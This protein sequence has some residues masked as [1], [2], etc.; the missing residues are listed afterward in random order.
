MVILSSATAYAN[1]CGYPKPAYINGIVTSRESAKGVVDVLNDELRKTHPDQTVKLAYNQTEGFTLDLV[2]S[3]YQKADSY[4]M[5]TADASLLI[6]GVIFGRDSGLRDA[7]PGFLNDI[8]AFFASHTSD[9]VAQFSKVKPVYNQTLKDITGIMRDALAAGPGLYIITHSQGSLFANDALYLLDQNEL[10]AASGKR[11]STGTYFIAP[12][13]SSQLANYGRGYTKFN[14]DLL[15]GLGIG[16]AG[17]APLFASSAEEATYASKGGDAQYHGMLDA[18]FNAS[19]VQPFQRSYERITQ[20]LTADLDALKAPCNYVES[21][22]VVDGQTFTVVS[23]P[24][25]GVDYFHCTAVANMLSIA[26]PARQAC[27]GN[28]AGAVIAP[29]DAN[30]QGLPINYVGKC[31]KTGESVTC[32]RSFTVTQGNMEQTLLSTFTASVSRREFVCKT[33]QFM[34]IN[35]STNQT[36]CVD[37]G[38]FASARS[39]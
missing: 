19:G 6:Y 31:N 5:R 33:D 20:K 3:L 12:A 29:L 38:G 26:L 4:H 1:Q 36:A 16:M 24:V 17:N 10:S 18:Y 35:Q 27:L 13:A 2:E 39:I 37:W 25:L 7:P 9:L 11:A 28:Y 14:E 23:D 8:K 22:E 30:G 34:V 15:N 21:T 32:S